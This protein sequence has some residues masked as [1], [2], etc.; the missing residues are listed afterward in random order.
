M[1]DEKIILLDEF[2]GRL[3][4]QRTLSAGL[5]QALEAHQA[6]PITA[7]TETLGQ[8]SFQT[9]FRYFPRIAGTTGTAREAIAEFWGS[10]NLRIVSIPSHRPVQ[11]IW[12]AARIF[13][14]SDLRWQAVVQTVT[15]SHAKGQPVLIGVRSVAASEQLAHLLSQQGWTFALLNA[16]RH[17]YEAEIVATA[18]QIGAITIA[19]NM[20]GR[21]T[22]IKLGTGV[23]ALGGLQVVIVEYNDSERVDR[24][25]AGRCG[26]QGDPGQ[27]RVF[28]SLEDELIKRYLPKTGQAIVSLAKSFFGP[29]SDPFIRLA[30]R[31]AQSKAQRQARARRAMIV[32]NDEWLQKALPFL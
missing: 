12:Q 21:G 7:P 24:Q 14:Q 11:R 1:Q 19:T 25:L 31:L 30:F 23:A 3:T 28:L 26:R 27:V 5:H 22:D 13:R 10:Y 16:T 9:F 4:P 32:K 2:T 18:G 6:L 29:M 17:E 20:A 8:M 15:E